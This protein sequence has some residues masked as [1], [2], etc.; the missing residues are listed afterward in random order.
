MNIIHTPNMPQGGGHYSTCI[1]HNGLL[2]LS[3]QLPM[4]LKTKIVP[5][6]I[7][8]QTLL[9]LNNIEF[10]LNEAGVTKNDVLQA[11]IYVSDIALWGKVN[12][13]YAA[14]FGAHKPVRCVV[15]TGLLNY[16]CLI[17]I[18]I[19]AVKN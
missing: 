2:Y 15:P 1:E 19:V 12:V 8:E 17:E 5:E 3:G 18:E 10:I 16:G 13:V 7:E 9:V 6:T 4:D 14:F 11:R